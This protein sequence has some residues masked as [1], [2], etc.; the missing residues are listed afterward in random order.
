[1]DFKAKSFPKWAFKDKSGLADGDRRE[2]I[3]VANEDKLD[4]TE[5]TVAAT[6]GAANGIQLL[7]QLWR[8][9][10]HFVNDKYICNAPPHSSTFIDTNGLYENVCR[11]IAEANACPAVER[12]CAGV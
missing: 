9:H 10:G 12:S 5:G 11:S 4:P 8:E 3:E 7:E 1:M 6:D 2:L